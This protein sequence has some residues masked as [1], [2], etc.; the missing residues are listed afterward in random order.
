MSIRFDGKVAL[1]TG[2]GA[3][4]GLGRAHALALGRLGAKV[5]VNDLSLASAESVVAE[6]VA[7][8]GKA[9][10]LAADVSNPDQVFAMVDRVVAEWSTVHILVNNAGLLRDK[11]FAKMDLSDFRKVVDVHLLGSAYC[12]K[13]VWELMRAQNYGRIVMTTS[14]S[15]IYGNF[16]QANYGA[17]KAGVVG[18]MNVLAIEGKKNDIRVNSLAPT[19]ATEMT[20]GLLPQTMLDLLV[21]DTVSPGLLY[22]V[23]DNAPTQTILGAGG[24]C[25][26]VARMV[27]GQGVFLRG[28][29]LTVDGVADHFEGISDLTHGQP[30]GSAADQTG[31]YVNMAQG[32][33]V[34]SGS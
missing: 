31:K 13:A 27:E 16:G 3:G 8:G 23:S 33:T 15:G 25:F 24:G 6:I 19:A 20:A 5:V 14:G 4:A 29:A 30:L 32:A 21:P 34:A 12:T 22:L 11:T 18:L 28:A 17:A 9:L 7:A 1:I 26:A 2:A 10:A